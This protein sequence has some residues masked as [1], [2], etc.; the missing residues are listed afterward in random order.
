MCCSRTDS[1]GY[2]PISSATPGTPGTPTTPSLS[3]ALGMLPSPGAATGTLA[4]PYSS[5][6]P[7]RMIDPLASMAA[8]ANP[9]Q[10]RSRPQYLNLLILCFTWAVSW[11][12]GNESFC[13]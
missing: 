5:G 13:I 12:F 7:M 8:S 6:E 3:S 2:G 10:V 11:S 4:G 1:D 9:S